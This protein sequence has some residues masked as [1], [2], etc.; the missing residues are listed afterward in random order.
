MHFGTWLRAARAEEKSK[1]V[2]HRDLACYASKLTPYVQEHLALALQDM[3]KLYAELPPVLLEDSVQRVFW[4]GFRE[5]YI[6]RVRGSLD[7]IGAALAA[8]GC[9]DDQ[10]AQVGQKDEPVEE[11]LP[12]PDDDGDGEE[13]VVEETL[14]IP[15]LPLR[16][17]LGNGA[18]K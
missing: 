9:T 18:E 1:G 3:E 16:R 6:S 17:T 5:E 13:D 7:H 11:E 14:T 12:E 2:S 15:V 10:L 4:E 8:V